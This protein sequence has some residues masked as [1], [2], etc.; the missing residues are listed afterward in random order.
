M[1]RPTSCYGKY[2]KV[3][4]KEVQRK[5]RVVDGLSHGQIRQIMLP[6]KEHNRRVD[7]TQQPVNHCRLAT[8]CT[9][10]RRWRVSASSPQHIV[11]VSLVHDD[12]VVSLQFR[13]CSWVA[14]KGK[15]DCCQSAV[16]SLLYQVSQFVP[17]QCGVSCVCICCMLL[18]PRNIYHMP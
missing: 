11:Y 9:L 2:V 3:V 14:V 17:C 18:F 5:A 1:A 16:G 10:G 12:E 4:D 6:A 8:S 15:K 7:A 13:C